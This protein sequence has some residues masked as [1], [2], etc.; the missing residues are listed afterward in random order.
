MHLCIY[1]AD[2]PTPEHQARFGTYADMFESWLAPA[3]PEAR[4]SRVFIAAGE[5]P[6][7]PGTVDGVLITGSRA[8]VH[9]GDDWINDLKAHLVQ[10]RAACIP[11]G[12]ICFGHQI[13]AEA[14]GGTVARSD[15]GWTIGR[16]VHAASPLGASL[17]GREELAALSFH[18]DQ[19]VAPPPEARPLMSS[20]PSPHGGFQY[21]FQALTVQVHPEL[22]AAYVRTLLHSSAVGNFPETTIAEAL[23]TLEA[24]VE[25]AAFAK[26]FAHFYR[27][28]PGAG[29]AWQATRS[30]RPDAPVT[31]GE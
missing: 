5:A 16:H 30:C 13:I 24:S 12:G 20:P 22:D 18:Q 21:D 19:V 25:A 10:L 11:M 29:P 17:F 31:P 1:E 8:G 2:R 28:G 27:Q 14:F 23:A 3:L 6:P 7:A 15:T 9:D 4:F 26:G